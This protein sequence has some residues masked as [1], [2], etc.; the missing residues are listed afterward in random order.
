MRDTPRCGCASYKLALRLSPS[1]SPSYGRGA[2]GEGQSRTAGAQVTNLRY[3][4]RPP[5]LP[6]MGEGLGVRVKRC[7]FVGQV[8]SLPALRRKPKPRRGCA[9]YKLALQKP[10]R[11]RFHLARPS[12]KAELLHSYASYKLALRLSPSPSPPHGRRDRGEGQSRAADAQVPNLR[13]I[14]PSPSYG[15]GARGEGQTR[16][17]KLQTCATFS[18]FAF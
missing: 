3:G 5:P 7:S 10:C 9:S 12:R 18:P 16:L 17:R 15:R 6:P 13:H 2:E 8:F 11:A 4:F 1:P 14:F